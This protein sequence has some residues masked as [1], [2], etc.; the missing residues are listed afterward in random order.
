MLFRSNKKGLVPET[1]VVGVEVVDDGEAPEDFDNRFS[2]IEPAEHN[3]AHEGEDDE[4][5]EA[6]DA[7]MDIVGL[8]NRRRLLPKSCQAWS[9]A[10]PRS[11]A[12]TL[13]YTGLCEHL[14]A[15]L[16]DMWH[17]PSAC[18]ADVI[19]LHHVPS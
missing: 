9:V 15:W 10:W 6:D 18:E 2:C 8:P 16:K 13:L 17:G 7:I 1:D 14:L 19:P 4:K 11:K 3:E 5:T 12:L